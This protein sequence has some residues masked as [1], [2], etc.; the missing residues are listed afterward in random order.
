M[1]IPFVVLELDKPR[2]LRFGMTAT[3]LIEQKFGKSLSEIDWQKE[4]ISGFLRAASC[5][6]VDEVLTEIRLA[7]L[8]DEY[9]DQTT[10][11]ELVG[12]AMEAGYGKNE[13]VTVEKKAKR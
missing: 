6:L 10:F 4:G 2:K 9:L 8:V 11:M 13:Q 12:K 3:Y 5:A 1:A 7:E